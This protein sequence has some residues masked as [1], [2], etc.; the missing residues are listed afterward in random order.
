MFLNL[1]CMLTDSGYGEKI[2]ARQPRMTGDSL[3]SDFSPVSYFPYI[4]N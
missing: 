2:D 3:F 1:K 4:S